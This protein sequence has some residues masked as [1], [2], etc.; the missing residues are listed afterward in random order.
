MHDSSASE[1]YWGNAW[2]IEKLSRKCLRIGAISAF[3][4]SDRVRISDCVDSRVTKGETSRANNRRC[5]NLLSA[6]CCGAS[7]GAALEIQCSFFHPP[8]PSSP[9]T[10]TIFLIY[11]R[12]Q[13]YE[14]RERLNRRQLDRETD[15]PLWTYPPGRLPHLGQSP[16]GH[17][18]PFPACIGHSPLHSVWQCDLPTAW[19]NRAEPWMFEVSP[20]EDVRRGNMSWGWMSYTHPVGQTTT[21]HRCPT[22]RC[23]TTLDAAIKMTG[24]SLRVVY[25]P[26]V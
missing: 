15:I 8:P 19:N 11:V 5:C 14:S 3:V 24:R 25:T 13:C 1:C 16:Y 20:G 6:A 22:R 18:P 7:Q 9:T 10:T 23:Q 2:L 26:A 17:F 12:W 4:E 21:M